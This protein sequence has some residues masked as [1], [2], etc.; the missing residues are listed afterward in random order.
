M[1][2]SDRLPFFFFFFLSS[3]SVGFSRIVCGGRPGPRYQEASVLVL[4]LT[5]TGTQVLEVSA[6]TCP[7]GW[8]EVVWPTSY[9]AGLCSAVSLLSP[10]RIE[11]I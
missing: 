8:P 6:G 10:F 3:L 5:G 2:L 11:A 9:F 4:I 7:Q 1:R